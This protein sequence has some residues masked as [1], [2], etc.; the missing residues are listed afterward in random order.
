MVKRT[1]SVLVLSIF[2]AHF[3]GFY[4]YFFV[5]LKQVRKEMRVKLKDLPEEEL[6]L[7][8]LS[9]TEYQKAKIE[10]HEIRVEG[11][12]YDIARVEEKNGVILVYCLH[13][14]AEDNLLA[15]LDKIL[16]LPLKD[17]KAPPQLIKFVSLSFIVPQA[18]AWKEGAE[19]LFK[20]FTYYHL[21]VSAFFPTLHSPPPRLSESS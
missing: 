19:R 3:A 18:F 17:K 6:E 1:L 9:F 10:E 20:S 4:V 21:Y 12:M 2:L 14:K 15:F 8:K 7:I 5:Q 16:T 13:D 11:K